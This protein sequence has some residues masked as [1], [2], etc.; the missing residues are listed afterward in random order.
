MSD[1]IFR[2]VLSF[3]WF[4]ESLFCAPAEVV[5]DA[6][7]VLPGSCGEIKKYRVMKENQ[8]I[9]RRV[10]KCDKTRGEGTA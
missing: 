3:S 5:S 8:A 1:L 6:F 9:K 10:E 4:I 7:H 2:L